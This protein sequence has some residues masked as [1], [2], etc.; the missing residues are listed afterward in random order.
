MTADILEIFSSL[1]GEGPFAGVK[2]IFIRFNKCNLT[3]RYCDVERKTPA[4]QFTVSKLVSI[5]KSSKN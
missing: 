5:V 3:C 2:Q 4:K 1:Q